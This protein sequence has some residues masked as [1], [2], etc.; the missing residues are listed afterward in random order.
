LTFLSDI[1]AF[2]TVMVAILIPLSIEIISRISERYNSE[3]LIYVFQKHW[4]YKILFPLLL[5]NLV[6]LIILKFFMT[7]EYTNSLV[8]KI[9]AWIMLFIFII[10][11]IIVGLVI[12]RIIKFVSD[13]KYVLDQL[14]QNVKKN[15]E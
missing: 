2:E 13:P 1:I 9:I 15:L 4:G 8:W 12:N 6:V 10:I 5:F 7:K 11:A 3:V 14:Y